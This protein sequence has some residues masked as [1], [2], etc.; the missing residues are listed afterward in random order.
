M[1]KTNSRVSPQTFPGDYAILAISYVELG[2]TETANDY[3]KR[4]IETMK[5]D[6]FKDN[7]EPP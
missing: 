7:E 4:F 3:R 6:T 2:K 1:M 5:R